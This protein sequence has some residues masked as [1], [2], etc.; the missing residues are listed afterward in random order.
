MRRNN[1]QKLA[2]TNEHAISGE[3]IGAIG[4]DLRRKLLRRQ[5]T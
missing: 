1:L 5:Y 4:P 2:L 3:G